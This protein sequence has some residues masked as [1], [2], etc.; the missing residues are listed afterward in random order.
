MDPSNLRFG[1]GDQETHLL[2]LTLVLLLLTSVLILALPRKYV[3]LPFLLG[4]LLI[5]MGQVLVI[6]GMHFPVFRILILIGWARLLAA[7][8]LFSPA[9]YGFKLN[10]IDRAMIWW[11]VAAAI[12]FTLRYLDVNAL[13]NRIG[14]AYSVLGVY[15]FMRILVVDAGDADRV[16]KLLAVICAAVA[17]FMALEQETGR[18]VFSMFGGVSAF[19]PVREGRIRSQGPFSISIIAGTMGASLL[20]LFMGLWWAHKARG[21]AILGLVAGSVMAITSASATPLMAISAAVIALCF[22]PFRR[23]MGHVRC[24]LVSILVSL[25]LVMKAPVWAL[26]GRFDFVGGSSGYHRYQLINQTILHFGDWWL[27]GFNNTESWGYLMHDTAN[28]FVDT[29][30]TGGLLS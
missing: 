7:G 28:A 9:K 1:G 11:T 6:G 14:N 8:M 29:A 4:C 19:T 21:F 16:V 3:V 18:N 15:F 22:W 30:V 2:P 10:A 17:A 24:V 25:H 20:P 12:T 13:T 23:K 26:I 27:L 5:P